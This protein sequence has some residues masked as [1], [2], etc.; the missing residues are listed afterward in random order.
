MNNKGVNI[1]TIQRTNHLNSKKKKIKFNNG[2]KTWKDISLKRRH[3]LPSGTQK[4]F[5]SLITREM[6]IKT[7]MRH[8][9]HF[10]VMFIMKKKKER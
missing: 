8:S 4:V 2:Q 3:K 6:Q 7:T 9:L 1:Q 5:T 10:P